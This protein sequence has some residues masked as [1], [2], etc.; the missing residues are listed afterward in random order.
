MNR[1]L[2]VMIV[3]N[4]GKA[5]ADRQVQLPVLDRPFFIPDNKTVIACVLPDGFCSLICIFPADARQN[6]PEF[7][8]AIPGRMK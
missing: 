4:G 6:H 3:F 1:F 8:P 7:L 2:S 5:D